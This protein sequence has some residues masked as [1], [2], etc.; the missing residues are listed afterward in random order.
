M[1]T[2]HRHI[3]TA[4][5]LTLTTSVVMAGPFLEP[6]PTSQNEIALHWSE[7]D[8]KALSLKLFRND[9]LIGEFPATN[10]TYRD[11]SIEPGTRYTY[12]VTAALPDGKEQSVSETVTSLRDVL[13]TRH[14]QLVVIGG[15]ASGVGVAVSAARQGVKVALIE[16]SDR[17]GGMITNGVAVTDMRK[18]ARSNGLFDEIRQSVQS[19]YGTGNGL[20]YEPKV[21]WKIIRNMVDDQPL[22]DVF[23]RM[24]YQSAKRQGLTVTSVT[25]KDLNTGKLTRFTAD[26]F[27]DAT[28]EG[29]MLDDLG[30]S[31]RV[32]R[33]A[34]S[35]EEPHAGFI[36]YDRFK[37]EITPPST[38]KADRKI[39]AYSFLLPLKDYGT[40]ADKS[41]PEPHFYDKS[42]YKHTTAWKE[43][44]AYMYG[45]FPGG[46]FEMNQHPQGNDLQEI[47]F[48]YPWMSEKQRAKMT[49]RFRWHALGYLHY[50]QTEQ[51]LKQLGLADDEYPENSN[52]PTSLYVRE[53]RRMEG[54]FMLNEAD[55]TFARKRLRL[56]TVGIGDYP[57][58]S[59]AIHKKTDWSNTDLGEGEY[60]LYRQTPW[61]QVPFGVLLPRELDNL[62]VTSAVSATHV[63]YGTLRMEPVRMA[64]GQAAGIAIGMAI[65][66]GRTPAE[67]PL[68]QLQRKLV[69]ANAYMGWF[70]DVTA[71]TPRFW[72]IQELAAKAVLTDEELKSE[73][74][75]G[76]EEMI[77]CLY[78][79]M[80]FGYEK[81]ARGYL[82]P[83]DD[84]LPQQESQLTSLFTGP[85]L[86]S[87][88]YNSEQLIPIMRRAAKAKGL[89]VKATDWALRPI[90]IS[91]GTITKEQFYASLALILRGTNSGAIMHLR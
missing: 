75:I 25:C 5:V 77:R 38:G 51:G 20:S 45:R 66:G 24:S 4:L 29:D 22:I 62:M 42:N 30:V 87:E 10:R 35:D 65:S 47:N 71:E 88:T 27:V 85:I 48:K 15:T 83:K 52:I 43:T 31:N 39:Q 56:D 63:G 8:S 59:H 82:Q 33:E 1:L 36:H 84:I 18:P 16:P 21:T 55:V 7:V 50:L 12:R 86:K 67:V 72:A 37:D 89:S 74:P 46:K 34:R 40:G 2:K 53:A 19:Y 57:M 78:K 9:A 90:T 54:E 80:S 3:L 32:G 70:S 41:I 73:Q 44:W 17:L 81:H 76:Y 11:Q 28:I 6:V 26:H 23:H 91:E 61:Y 13:P 79:A 68:E 58:D 60:W 69:E 64:M 14:Y 49:D